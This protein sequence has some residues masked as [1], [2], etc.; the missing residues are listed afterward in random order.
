M[1]LL[2]FESNQGGQLNP[3]QLDNYKDIYAYS[4]SVLNHLWEYTPLLEANST[5]NESINI[6]G[7]EFIHIIHPY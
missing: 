4:L 7:E 6:H 1:W 5:I 3:T 2:C